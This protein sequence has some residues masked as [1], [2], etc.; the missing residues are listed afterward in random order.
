MGTGKGLKTASWLHRT[1]SS[2]STLR[3]PKAGLLMLGMCWSLA[4]LL[5]VSLSFSSVQRDVIVP[6]A[7]PE[8]AVSNPG[9]RVNPQPG[10]NA[11]GHVYAEWSLSKVRGWQTFKVVC[12]F[13]HTQNASFINQCAPKSF[14][15]APKWKCRCVYGISDRRLVNRSLC[16]VMYYVL[17]SQDCQNQ[18]NC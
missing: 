13:P 1:L 12:F 7:G 18:A 5:H 6:E 8:A 3:S 2:P 11:E 4:Q 9:T 15:A 10:W 17:I 14:I 16:W